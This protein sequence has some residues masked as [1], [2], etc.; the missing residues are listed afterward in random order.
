MVTNQT[1]LQN[2]CCDA[3]KSQ[4]AYLSDYF[5]KIYWCSPWGW[6]SLI[7]LQGR[8]MC[9]TAFAN[10]APCRLTKSV[11]HFLPIKVKVLSHIYH[12]FKR[13]AKTH[14]VITLRKPIFCCLHGS[15]EAMVTNMTHPGTSVNAN[16]SL[17][18]F[19]IWEDS[20]FLSFGFAPSSTLRRTI[21]LMWA[22]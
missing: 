5:G 11:Y 2:H 21:Q 14:R 22:F 20:S 12:S 13:C 9:G 6:D 8:T 18:S 19:P 4:V 1:P 7:S 3:N 10:L 15:Q 17:S 16:S